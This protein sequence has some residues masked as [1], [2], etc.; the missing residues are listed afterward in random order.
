MQYAKQ[1]WSGIQR[2]RRVEPDIA[3]YVAEVDSLLDNPE[4]GI[5]ESLLLANI[6]GELRHKEASLACDRSCS[7]VLEKLLAKAEAVD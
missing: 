1:D 6:F 7:H 5:D 3:A 2:P 4:E